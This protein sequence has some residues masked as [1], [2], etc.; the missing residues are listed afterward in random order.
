MN[1]RGFTIGSIALLA[2]VAHELR[3]AREPV[4]LVLGGG[5]CRDYGHIGALRVLESERLRPDLVVGSSAGSLV[6]AFYAAGVPVRD[7]E[8]I[9]LRANPNMLRDWIFPKLGL[10]GGDG[11]ARF[12][13]ER[14]RFQRIEDLPM[15][16]G[17][18]AANLRTGEQ[19]IIDRGDLARAVQASSSA[20]G[21]LEPV[22]L[23][24]RMLVDGNFAAPVPVAAARRLGA[25][26]IVAVDVTF[27]PGQADLSDPYDAL[28]QGISILTR[29]LATEERRLA[30]L[31]IEPRLP[32][33]RDMSQATLKTTMDA[34]EAAAR[35]RLPDLRRL[36]AA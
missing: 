14:I 21:L 25:A 32:E 28:Y 11:I 35:S 6:G 36:M 8:G 27:P 19:V 7:I 12:V 3:A 4:A 30:D 29:K 15:R 26:R 34:G 2:T 20:H 1:R 13:R 17:A 31:L 10:F 5:G 23:N 16:F 24:G 22:R 18:V 9:G 33:H